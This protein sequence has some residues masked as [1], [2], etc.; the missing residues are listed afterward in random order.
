MRYFK[1]IRNQNV[2]DVLHYDKSPV[3]VKFQSAHAIPVRCGLK[4]A[5]GIMSDNEKI[6]NTS[7]FLPFP[8]SGMYPTVT[9]E[10]ITENEYDQLLD[11]EFKSADDIRKELVLEMIERGIL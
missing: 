6:Y 9:M 8:I 2:V 3:Y 1:F 4:D 10:E 5:Q 11:K 7:A